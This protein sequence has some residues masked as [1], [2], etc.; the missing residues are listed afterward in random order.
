MAMQLPELSLSTNLVIVGI[1]GMTVLYGVMAGHSKVR[2]LAMSTYVGIVLAAQLGSGLQHLLA[3]NG[4]G[5]DGGIVRLILFAAPIVLLEISRRHHGRGQ[6]TGM[7]VTVILSLLTAG[8]IIG[9]GL[10]QLTGSTL[11]HI[12]DSSI[13]AFE[14]YT[15]RLWLVA[16]LPVFIIAEAFVGPG[17]SE[18]H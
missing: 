3:K 6:H 15:Y 8:L 7:I 17:R 14:I 12:T 1:I 2:N 4:H 18:K 13:I 16:I 11:K 10:G 9:M 5:L